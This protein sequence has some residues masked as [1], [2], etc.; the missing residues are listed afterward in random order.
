ML[1]NEWM[2]LVWK[3]VRRNNKRAVGR[4]EDEIKKIKSGA[5]KMAQWLRVLLVLPKVLSSMPSNHMVA[6]NHL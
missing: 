1:K 6:H 5:G 2:E 3:G 4:K